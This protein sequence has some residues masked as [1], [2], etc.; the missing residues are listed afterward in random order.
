M[1]VA[2]AALAAGGPATRGDRGAREGRPPLSG[3]PA[4]RDGT[5]GPEPRGAPLRE[6]AGARRSGAGARLLGTGRGAGGDRVGRRGPRDGQAPRGGGEE[7]QP[8]SEA[9][10]PAPR[11]RRV[12][13]GRLRAGAGASRRSARAGSGNAGGADAGDPGRPR[14]RA[15]APRKGSRGGAGLPQG[16]SGLP[17]E[18]RRVVA[19]RSALRRRRAAG[20][21]RFAPD[22]DDAPGSDAPELRHGGAS[23]RDRRRSRRRSAISRK[24]ASNLT[25][26][27]RAGR[28]RAAPAARMTSRR[29]ATPASI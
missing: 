15:G 10:S 14:R 13:E 24:H 28:A 26:Q 16:G 20:R 17:G 9:A 12:S 18:S 5:G 2:R 7:E 3:N 6:G 8:R 23:L 4:D 27:R 21:V 19:P 25:P 1:G 11:A 29:T 22:R